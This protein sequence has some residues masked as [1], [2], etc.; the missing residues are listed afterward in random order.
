[1]AGILRDLL[2]DRSS[3]SGGID[4]GTGLDGRPVSWILSAQR[5][6]KRISL[7][8]TVIAVDRSSRLVRYWLLK[9]GADGKWIL[10]SAE[11][12][13]EALD[14][15]WIN[16]ELEETIGRLEDPQAAQSILEVPKAR[17]LDPVVP[18]PSSGLWPR[19][20]RT[21]AGLAFFFTAFF[22]L[23]SVGTLQ[24]QKMIH[25]VGD[26]GS[27]IGLSS[28][29]QTQAVETLSAR[30]EAM[31]DELE[32][33]RDDIQRERT[34]FEFSRKNTAMNLR[35][36]ADE[37]PWKDYS[38]KRAYNYLAD[39]I[40]FSGSYG[41]IIYQL[42]RVPEDNAQAETI[43]AVDRANIIP[44]SAYSSTVPGLSYPVR[45]DGEPPDGTDF[46]ISSGFGELRPSSLGTGGY[47]PHMAVDIINV[48]NILTVT[49][50]NSIVRFPGEP[51]SVV[52]SFDGTVL[53]C[54]YDS[55]YGWHVE[56]SHPLIP[57]WIDKYRG[58]EM[59]ST[60]YAHMSEDPGW[61]GGESVKQNE[62]LGKIGDT[63][64]ATGPHLH[65]EVRIYR[66]NGEFA[67]KYGKFDRIN[68]YVFRESSIRDSTASM[69][70]GQ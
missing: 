34:A 16:D 1:L 33:L 47:L 17:A 4:S 9:P 45:L 51:G 62:K 66:K 59:L 56:V 15:E 52:S 49:P 31:D 23:A 43:M 60:F 3:W 14:D 24:Y 69:T 21:A 40:E 54:G 18:P 5:A 32:Q 55:V 19:R 57:E 65:Y 6:G 63:G 12:N 36:Q 67:G 68:P 37:L 58:I 28:T 46:M 29:R 7:L 26:L 70:A 8:E 25:L 38:R 20:F 61:E 48:K 22:I 11:K 41:D 42:S 2:E 39:R 50:D 10:E 53:G 13:H 64:R 30:L 44:L 27:A 35:Q